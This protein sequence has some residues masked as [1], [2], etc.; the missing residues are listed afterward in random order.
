MSSAEKQ[1]QKLKAKLEKMTRDLP[2]SQLPTIIAKDGVEVIRSRT[3]NGFGL[4][5]NLRTFKK[6]KIKNST[7]KRRERHAKAGELS[8]KTSPSIA[9][10]T[11]SGSLIDKLKIARVTDKIAKIEP[12]NE[13]DKVQSRS[14]RKNP[15]TDQQKAQKL[16]EQGINFIGFTRAETKRLIDKNVVPFVVNALNRLFK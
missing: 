16:K 6:L 12:S 5:S 2:S 9:N 4:S 11:L 8:S 14:N 13:I 15:R 10:L 7:V 1:I 3:R